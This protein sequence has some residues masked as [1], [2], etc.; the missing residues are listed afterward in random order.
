MI[1]LF[2]LKSSIIITTILLQN[3]IW[4]SRY[5]DIFPCI[6][7]TF[8]QLCWLFFI[9]DNTIYLLMS[10]YLAITLSLFLG[11][12]IY[13]SRHCTEPFSIVMTHLVFS[14]KLQPLCFWSIQFNFMIP[15]L[16]YCHTSLL[17]FDCNILVYYSLYFFLAS[18]YLIS[19]IIIPYLYICSLLDVCIIFLL[20]NL[21]CIL[22]MLLISNFCDWSRKHSYEVV[23]DCSL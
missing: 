16:L 13:F 7:P 23:A 5:H 22:H 12:F 19:T 3:H 17:Y 14:P 21:A 20:P 9:Y 15:S 10:V 6:I 18:F 4:L 2:S 8:K 11:E 1:L